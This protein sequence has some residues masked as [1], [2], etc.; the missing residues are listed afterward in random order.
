MLTCLG[1]MSI[2]AQDRAYNINI[3]LGSVKNGTKAYLIKQY[4][5]TNQETLDSAV[6]KDGMLVFQGV[7]AEPIKADVLVSHAGKTD[8]RWA[9]D[10]DALTIYVEKGQMNINGTDSIKNAEVSGSKIN[11]DY[12]AYFAAVLSPLVEA[13]NH[14]AR[15]YKAAS[16]AQKKDRGFVDEIMK[17]MQDAGKRADSLKY[18][19]IKQHPESW[20]SLVALTEVAG[21][22]PNITRIEPLFGALSANLRETAIGKSL[23]AKLYDNGP[24][25]ISALAPDFTEKNVNGKPVKLSD[26]RGQYVLLDFWASWCGPCRAENPNIVRAYNKYKAKGFTILGVSLDR[27]AQKDAWLAAIKKDGL[28]WT[29]V[30]DLKFWDGPAAKLYGIQSIPQNFLVDPSGKIIAKNLRGEALELELAKHLN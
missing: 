21:K 1:A 22:Q 23:A 20:L 8:T 5:W 10:G 27:E 30:S 15:E 28:T 25:G 3:K 14:V 9:K 11:D 2:K 17:K 12:K 19:Y 7:T 16:E 26:F 24:T 29:Q 18:I 13:N 4:G 6:F